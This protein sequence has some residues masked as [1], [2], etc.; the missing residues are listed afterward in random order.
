MSSGLPL[1]VNSWRKGRVKPEAFLCEA[2]RLGS[3]DYRSVE[4]SNF[5]GSA[6]CKVSRTGT[7][8]GLTVWFDAAL[9][10]GIGFSNAP[11]RPELIYGNAF[12]PW[13][14]PVEIEAGDEIGIEVRANLVG[15]DYVWEWNTRVEGGGGVKASFRQSTFFASPISL[16]QLKKR[17][18]GFVPKSGEEGEIDGFVLSLMK[19]ELSLGEI[20]EHV[21][22]RYP[23]RFARVG[24]AL[25]RVS[26][27]AQK[28]C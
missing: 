13:E 15:E 23:R 16:A 10:E 19:G 17:S 28:Y 6:A 22:Q 11:G 7:G 8:H 26:D 27:L 14:R 1:V 9:A 20:A 24:S 3:I 25:G 12:F 5:R 21:E 4:D 2:A 18:T